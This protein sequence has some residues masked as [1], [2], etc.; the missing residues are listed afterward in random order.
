MF[1]YIQVIDKPYE[2]EDTLREQTLSLKCF[3]PLKLLISLGKR[4]RAFHALIIESVNQRYVIK[5][6]G[7]KKRSANSAIS[8]KVCAST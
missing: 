5:V 8:A 6:G 7:L 1:A 4:F 3:Q 2:H